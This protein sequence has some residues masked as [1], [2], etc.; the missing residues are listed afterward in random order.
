VLHPR[1]KVS[2]FQRAGW[3]ADWIAA[4]KKIVRDEFDASYRF[5]EQVTLT[6]GPEK[7]NDSSS[8]TNTNIFDTLP[9]FRADTFGHLDE[10]TRYLC[11]SPEDV[12]NED[13]LKWWY[14]HKHVFPHLSRMALDY[15]TIP[16]K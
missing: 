7:A 14:E 13:V 1:H 3:T 15:H 4:A 2:Y 8:V 11:T 10:L 16:C 6:T 9:A 5:R 12:K